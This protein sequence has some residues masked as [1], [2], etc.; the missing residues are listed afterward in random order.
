MKPL[1]MAVV[2]VVFCF[3][4][5]FCGAE[6]Q[7]SQ[8]PDSVIFLTKNTNGNQVHYGVHVDERCRPAAKRPVYAYW[9]MLEKGPEERAGLMFW[10]QPGYGV[11]QPDEVS[12]EDSGGRFT[13]MIRGVP[14]RRIRVET[15]LADKGCRARAFTTMNGE[16]ALFR[17]IDI[18]VSGWANVHRVEIHGLRPTD[19][20]PVFEVTHQD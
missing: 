18:E 17:R 15:F 4:S 13:F 3:G 7:G 11:K 2:I 19:L 16:D 12:A 9:R 8:D 6:I 14:E 20:L 1:V 10:E 5:R